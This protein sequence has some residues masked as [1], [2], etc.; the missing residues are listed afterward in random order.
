[1][2]ATKTP[3]KNFE[4][5]LPKRC[6]YILPTKN[7]AKHLEKALKQY[8]KLLTPK[9]ELIVIDGGSTDKTY[10]VI[11]K[12]KKFIDIF[13]SEPDVIVAHAFNKGILLAKGKYIKNLADDDVI[14]PKAME[15]AL[16][17]MEENPSVDVMVCGGTKIYP[18]GSKLYYIP[19]GIEY[20]NNPENVIRYGAC[21]IGFLMR[22]RVFSKIGLIPLIGAADPAFI[23]ECVKRDVSVKFCRIN[24]FI[25]PILNHSYVILRKNEMYWNRLNLIKD[26]CSKRFYL[27]T[28]LFEYI[29]I[30]KE[31]YYIYYNKLFS[32]QIMKN[33]IMPYLYLKLTLNINKKNLNK[34]KKKKIPAV[35]DN[36]LS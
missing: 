24:L 27:K 29:R 22:R 16:K 28:L 32:F 11:K 4:D 17:I 6:S 9:D 30:L 18:N 35:W 34:L 23:L 31:N 7:R 13:V 21:G 26:Y 36:S 5:Y 3:R 1:M 14:Y 10:Q 15:Q 25:H 19:K 2:V 20:T 8:I 33:L 12:Y